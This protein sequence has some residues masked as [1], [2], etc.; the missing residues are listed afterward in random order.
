MLDPELVG[1][2]KRHGHVGGG[3]AILEEVCHWGW[4]LRVQKDIKFSATAPKPCI[5]ALNHDDNGLSLT[6]YE[7]SPNQMHSSVRVF[8]VVVSLHS[9]RED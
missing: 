9:N 2:I 8:L 6:N 5:F 4:A 7:Q 3:V 1:R